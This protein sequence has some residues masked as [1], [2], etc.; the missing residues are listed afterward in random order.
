MHI[1]HIA[2]RPRWEAAKLSG[3]YAQSTL[4]RTLEDEGFIHA[5]RAD[6]WET[7]RDTYY[8]EHTGPLVLLT[9][10]TDRLTSAWQEDEV[11]DTSFP[12]VYGPINVGA[13][14]D[15]RPLPRPAG[16]GPPQTFMQLFLTEFVWRI[17]VAV[18]FMVLVTVGGFVAIWLLGDRWALL[19][20]AAGL[21]VGIAA[22]VPLARRR[23][24]RLPGMG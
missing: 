12:H 23:R 1:F 6:Q 9:I 20:C 21:L 8:A 16:E 7:V 2:E 22:V 3:S 15:E 17:V 5:S 19:G 18:G 24:A 14:I 10:D 11:G 4:G 13:V